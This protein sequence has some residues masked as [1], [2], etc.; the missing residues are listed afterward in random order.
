MSQE[1]SFAN[2]RS[3]AINFRNLE[4]NALVKQ[5]SKI[6]T[7]FIALLFNCTNSQ[8]NFKKSAL[9]TDGRLNWNISHEYHSHPYG[10]SRVFNF[11]RE[12]SLRN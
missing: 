5:I 12:L 1:V 10:V 11:S 7:K 9:E 8:T 3:D 2:I 4:N 6:G